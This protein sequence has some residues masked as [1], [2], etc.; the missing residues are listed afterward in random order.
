MESPRRQ[1][2][3][4]QISHGETGIKLTFF[5]YIDMWKSFKKASDNIP[6]LRNI[7]PILDTGVA[8]VRN[9]ASLTLST[10]LQHYSWFSVDLFNTNDHKIK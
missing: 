10:F 6:T 5:F 9:T 3:G 4:L 8:G 2:T 1:C 7:N